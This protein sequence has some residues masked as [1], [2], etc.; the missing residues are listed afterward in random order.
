MPVVTSRHNQATSSCNSAL[1][2]PDFASMISSHLKLPPDLINV[3]ARVKQLVLHEYSGKCYI[4]NVCDGK[5]V[6]VLL[7]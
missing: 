4:N 1:G 5:F 3:R 7:Q 2:D 6:T